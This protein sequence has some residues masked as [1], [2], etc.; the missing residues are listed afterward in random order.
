MDAAHFHFDN[1]GMLMKENLKIQEEHFMTDYMKAFRED[2]IQFDE[3]TRDF[4]TGKMSKQEY[5]G[6]SGGFGSYA[7]RGG[8]SGMIRL[9]MTAGRLTKEKLAFVVEM[10]ERLSLNIIKLTT[11]ETIQLHGLTGRQILEVA[12]KALDH[13][14]VCRGGGGDHPRNVMAPPLSGVLPGETFDVI[15]YAEA[16]ADYLL[17][18][19][20]EI[21]LPRKLKVGFANHPSNQTHATMRDLGFVAKEDGTFDVYSAGG[22]GPNPKLGLRVATGVN[23]CDLL[24]YV[25][26]MVDTFLTYGN[27]ESRAKARTRYMQ[28][29]LGEEAYIKAFH[30]K[31]NAALSAGGLDLSVE[32]SPITK[33]GTGEISG[34]RIIPQKQKGLY[35]VSYHP[36]GGIPKRE[37]LRNLLDTIQDFEAVEVRL[38]ADGTMYIINCNAQEA[39]QV[40]KVTEDGAQTAFEHSVS[41]IGASICQQGVRDSQGLYR[42]CVQAVREAG[43]KDGALPVMHISGCPSSCGTHQVGVLGFHGG[44]KVVDKVPQPAFTLHVNGCE[45]LGSERFGEQWGTMLEKDIPE[46][47][48]ALGQKVQDSG[49]AFMD[50]Y[51]DHLNEMRELADKYLV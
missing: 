23:G 29:A 32:Q 28:E 15:P 16:V 35:A 6:I 1:L 43:L 38:G 24:Y 3:S 9:R 21:K 18:I 39:E 26:A 30:E 20:Y 33:T 40:L 31:L 48:V 44:T 5:K 19:L 11:C 4:Y 27:Y 25:R 45:T 13:G 42:A 12:T 47:L 36:L 17:S 49:K 51:P 7:E 41:C 8:K 2:L 34:Q 46:F 37:V 50:W 14:I 10:A 22:M